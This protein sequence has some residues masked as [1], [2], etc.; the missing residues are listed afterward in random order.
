MLL[1]KNTD[2]LAWVWL[3]IKIYRF[4]GETLYTTIY[5]ENKKY[6]IYF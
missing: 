2:Q 3:P 5:E 6:C 4:K 1:A